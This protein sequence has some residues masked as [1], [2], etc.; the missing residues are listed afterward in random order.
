MAAP[1]AMFIV[2]SNAEEIAVKEARRMGIP[3]VSVVDTNCDP[4][5]VDWIIPGNETRCAPSACSPP[6]LPIPSPRAAL[7]TSSPRLPIRSSLPTSLTR[8]AWINVDTSAYEQYEKQEGDFVEGTEALIEAAAEATVASRRGKKL[9]TARG[10]SIQR[11]ALWRIV[12]AGPFFLKMR[13]K[14]FRKTERKDEYN[15]TCHGYSS[16]ASE[17][18]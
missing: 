17:G 6:R 7:S 9:R 5:M 13:P 3:V 15:E 16:Q 10:Y 2:D 4:D 18:T 11:P 12:H 14:I 1:D 8:R